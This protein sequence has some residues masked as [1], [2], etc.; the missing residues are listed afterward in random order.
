MVRD[1]FQMVIERDMVSEV[2]MI[3]LDYELIDFFETNY[4]K[5]KTGYLCYFSFGDI[6][7]LNCDVILMEAEVASSENIGRIHAAGKEAGVW[8]VNML[9][10]MTSFMASDIDYIITVEVAQADVVRR[11][12]AIPPIRALRTSILLNTFSLIYH[13]PQCYKYTCTTTIV[14]PC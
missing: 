5:I 2:M 4:P 14:I 6:A 13:K 8:T 9:N 3:S 7:T 1:I 10:A 12:M 11:P